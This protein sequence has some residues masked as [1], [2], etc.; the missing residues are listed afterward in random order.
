M[1][2]CSHG[3]VSPCAAVSNVTDAPRHSEAA[4]T[5]MKRVEAKL[6]GFPWRSTLL[7]IRFESGRR[8]RDFRC[9]ARVWFAHLCYSLLRADR[10]SAAGNAQEWPTPLRQQCPF[11]SGCGAARARDGV[12]LGGNTRALFWVSARDASTETLASTLP[13]KNRRTPGPDEAA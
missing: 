10:D 8:P 7:L 12:H 1:R 2:C 5:F 3:A 11:S 6:D 9:R 13:T 4:T